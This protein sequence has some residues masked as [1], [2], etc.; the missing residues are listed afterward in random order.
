MYEK[1][2][3]EYPHQL[4]QIP[5]NITVITRIT[6]FSHNNLFANIVCVCMCIFYK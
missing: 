3:C 5:Y 2:K 1:K 6:N 4:A